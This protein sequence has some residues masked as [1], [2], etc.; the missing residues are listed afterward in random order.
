VTNVVVSSGQVSCHSVITS[1]TA[2]T[3]P[4]KSWSRTVRP[5]D[6]VNGRSRTW[7]GR[8]ASS[9]VPTSWP[10]WGAT[11][12]AV[13]GAVGAAAVQPAQPRRTATTARFMNRRMMQ[14][15]HSG[16][17]FL[18]R[19]PGTSGVSML[20][21]VDSSNGRLTL[22]PTRR[23]RHL[24]RTTVAATHGG[25]PP[26]TMPL[27]GTFPR[28]LGRESLG[29]V[30][31]RLRPRKPERTVAMRGGQTTARARRLPRPPDPHA[32]DRPRPRVSR[33]RLAPP[34]LQR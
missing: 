20:V 13:V 9:A 14:A 33:L 3:L 26:A 31:F 5:S 29:F 15:L 19:V 28:K 7:L 10:G 34:Q 22:P 23:R 17:L 8:A 2:T 21:T 24:L 32:P 4:A 16:T 25:S 27:S 6:A 30:R 1:E 18:I 12:A 11:L